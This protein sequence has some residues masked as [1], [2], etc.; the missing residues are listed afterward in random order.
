[1][2]RK[3][4]SEP[5]PLVD[6]VYRTMPVKKQTDITVQKMG[7]KVMGSYLLITLMYI[8]KK[9][10]KYTKFQKS[11]PHKVGRMNRGGGLGNNLF[12]FPHPYNHC[13]VIA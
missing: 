11:E 3:E 2:A 6:F 7:K 13:A 12:L 10:K 8:L 5:F 1:M 9:E 4:N